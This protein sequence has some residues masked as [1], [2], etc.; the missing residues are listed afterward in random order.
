M[1]FRCSLLAILVGCSSLLAHAGEDY[2]TLLRKGTN[3][4]E[5]RELYQ[6]YAAVVLP[7]ED[8]HDGFLNLLADRDHK[9]GRSG[10]VQSFLLACLSNG[11]E[12]RA[13][14]V[15]PKYLPPAGAWLYS[16]PDFQGRL[17]QF[18]ANCKDLNCFDVRDFGDFA[19]KSIRIG[20][21]V[22]GQLF[23]RPKF[24]G[25]LLTTSGNLNSIAGGFGSLKLRTAPR[26]DYL[27]LSGFR[28]LERS[29]L[30]AD[31]N[32]TSSG[33][34][35]SSTDESVEDPAANLAAFRLQVSGANLE[36]GARVLINGKA[37][38]KV[39]LD[40]RL[41]NSD[42]LGLGKDEAR[43][44]YH[45]DPTYFGFPILHYDSLSTQVVPCEVGQ[46]L[47]VQVVNPD[48]QIS[49]MRKLTVPSDETLDSDGDGLLDIW[50]TEGIEGLDLP[51]MGANP[52]K[53]DVFVEVDR[54]VVPYRIWSDFSERAYPRTQIFED[55]RK[56]FAK[57]PIINP[58]GTAGIALH[59]DYGQADF[60]AN[61]GKGMSRL[62]WRR[63]IGFGS[64]S[65]I[66]PEQYCDVLKLRNNEEFF[67]A[68]RRRVFRYCVFGDQQWNSRS[69][70]GGLR[71]TI[72][73][74]FGPS[75][76]KSIEAEYQLAI[77]VHELGHALGL[78]HTGKRGA[79]SNRINFNSLMNYR[80][81]FEGLDMD[82]SLTGFRL[83]DPDSE[84]GLG[85]H[86]FAFSEGMRNRLDEDELYEVLGI[87]NH[88]PHD[89]DEDGA[90]DDEP[91][92]HLLH[93][94][95]GTR[96]RVLEDFADWANLKFSIPEAKKSTSKTKKKPAK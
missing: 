26:I 84:E 13:Q 4:Q 55:A 56:I 39:T 36:P 18:P 65:Y 85:D 61:Q 58:D 37:A 76:M 5:V 11:W 19:P 95:K 10:F 96:G 70:G 75:R 57:A 89:W 52:L 24:R 41:D 53:K 21:R 71:S 32:S 44:G 83:P 66:K 67:D 9:N 2:R 8:E 90:L 94:G 23:R 33:S 91:V 28:E 77:F 81:T 62:D 30:Q 78:S 35:D 74:S 92:K 54:M 16:E 79:S 12:V 68:N 64:K 51:S 3:Q 15:D 46:Q 31:S 1:A 14:D 38:A 93:V 86:V 50:E 45:L 69:T 6:Q 40:T 22:R 20:P 34:N 27:T 47:S 60:G 49:K 7:T 42:W 17:R 87:A 29:N 80:F 72:F 43:A 73:L 59:V 25:R 88:F 63:Y 82:G 48:G